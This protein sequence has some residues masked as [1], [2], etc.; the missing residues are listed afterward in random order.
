M[1]RGKEMVTFRDVAVVFSEEE[2]GLLN[3]AQRKLYHDVMLENLRN[4]VSLGQQM[5]APESLLQPSRGDEL[6]VLTVAGWRRDPA[7][8]ENV[9]EMESLQKVGLGY[10]AHEELFCSQIWQQVTRELTRVRDLTVHT[11]ESSSPLK[12]GDEPWEEEELSRHSRQNPVLQAHHRE[13]HEEEAHEKDFNC[14]HHPHVITG[15]KSY[16]CEEVHSTFCPFSSLQPHQRVQDRC[17]VSRSDGLLK[18][19]S[20]R[21]VFPCQQSSPTGENTDGHEDSGDPGKN[22]CA[23]TVFLVCPG[24]EPYKCDECGASF[25]QT[26]C[27]QVH[28]RAH[29]GKKP[30]KCAECGKDFSWFSRLHAH[31]RVHTGE[32]PYKC[33]ECGKGFSSS[34]HLN[35]HCRVHT[36]EKPCK[37]EE[38]GKGFSSSSHLNI[39]CRVHTGEKPCK[40]EECGKASV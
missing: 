34:S 14:C 25:R 17:R 27:L 29:T 24:E 9:K 36:G 22:A 28:Q 1:A 39:H 31:H 8:D 20:Q 15:E 6:T 5:A 37:C 12:Q 35:I 21:P 3:P 11:G 38:C 13:G 23:Q 40:C 19:F 16:K 2:L 33:E 7:G 30:Y 10:L 4:V 26:S 32:K 18:N